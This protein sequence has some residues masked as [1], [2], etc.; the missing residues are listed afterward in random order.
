MSSTVDSVRESLL[1]AI[2][3]LAKQALTT[4]FKPECASAATSFAAAYDL[5]RDDEPVDKWDE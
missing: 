4:E 2:G 5:L 3:H 1:M